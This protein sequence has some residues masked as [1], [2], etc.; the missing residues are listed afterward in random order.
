MRRAASRME[1]AEG[2]TLTVWTAL[3]IARRVAAGQVA[4]GFHTPVTAFG[5]D[6]IL[7]FPH[8]TRTDL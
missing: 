1:T 2:Y 5:A 4:P 8:V 7:G 3:E 6:F